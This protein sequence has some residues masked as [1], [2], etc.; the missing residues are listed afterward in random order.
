[1]I[2]QWYGTFLEILHIFR[3]YRPHIRQIRYAINCTPGSAPGYIK[4]LD[5]FR[6]FF[7]DITSGY[8]NSF[9]L[10]ATL[11]P[12]RTQMTLVKFV[13]RLRIGVY[14]VYPDVFK[15]QVHF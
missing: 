11:E 12:E 15:L 1:L 10:A 14:L 3:Y 6:A 4:K 7:S 5:E 13:F 2:A 8:V 9:L